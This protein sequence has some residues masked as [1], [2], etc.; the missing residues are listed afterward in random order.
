MTVKPAPVEGFATTIPVAIVGAGAAG[1]CAS[2]AAHEAGAE[3]IVFE[4]DPL[5]RGSTALSAGLIP[6]AGTRFQRTLGVS[7]SAAQF[8]ADIRRKAHDEENSTIAELVARESG[9]TVEWLA[10]RYGL[11]FSLV[12]DFNYPGHSARR[13]H[14]LPSR[15]GAELIDRLHRAAEKAEITTI[16]N[17]TV[18]GLFADERGVIRGLEVTRPDDSIDHIGC[19]ALIL[20]CNGYGGAPD[21]VAKYIPE[22]RTAQ[23]FGHPGNRGD[24]VQWGQALGA[25]LRNMSGYQ[26]HGSVAHPHA[27]LITWAVIMEGGFQV[28][29]PG[30]RFS[31]ESLGY[32]EQAAVVLEQPDGIAFDIFDERIAAIARQFED[33]RQAEAAG[34]VIAAASIEELAQHLKLPPEALSETFRQVE[35]AKDGKATDP[36]GRPFAGVPHLSPPYRAVRVTG[37]LVHTQGGLAV[38]VTARVLDE[39]G[40]ALPNL[41]AAGGAAAGVSGSVAGG[42]LSGNGLLTATVLGRISGA[43]AAAL[44]KSRELNP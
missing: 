2:L 32:S 17:A 40:A 31:D 19:A 41:F 39:R 43:S 7:D 4:R 36:F 14:G 26:G 25:K 27:I 8:A 15:S 34:A 11:P 33:F 3:A 1:L 29:A 20:A 28:N 37:A 38:D 22:M 16:S 5:P 30:K 13:M 35:S 21:L 44:I 18:S 24:A 10:D 6:A 42:Y 23:Y 12:H 9:P